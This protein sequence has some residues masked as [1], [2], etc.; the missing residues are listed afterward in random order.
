[1][2]K[3]KIKA[4]DVCRFKSCDDSVKS[5]KCD[6]CPFVATH[7]EALSYHKHLAHQK[8]PTKKG[9]TETFSCDKCPYKTS[10]Q[11]K[12]VQHL[13]K[14]HGTVG[15][16]ECLTCDLVFRDRYDQLQH[17]KTVHARFKCGK[18]QFA[19]YTSGMKTNSII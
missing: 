16:W 3:H 17:K 2:N 8:K 13:D 4:H 9:A 18:C 11:D 6:I 7:R 14:F 1:M 19:T 5:L 12:L 10:G 15:E